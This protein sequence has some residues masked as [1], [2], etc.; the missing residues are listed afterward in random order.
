MCNERQ[1]FPEKSRLVNLSV[2]LIKK[3][4]QLLGYLRTID[5]PRYEWV[6][7]KLDLIYKANPEPDLVFNLRRKESLRRLADEYCE[8]IKKERLDAYREVLESQQV[9]FLADKIEKLI[10]VRQEQLDLE[11]PVTISDADIEA[12]RKQ[13]DIVNQKREVVVK[14]RGDTGAKWQMY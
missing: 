4:K 8:N 13:Y 14:A 12:A 3:R 7:E 10:F 1:P 2:T 11:I 5:Y 9:A 6:L